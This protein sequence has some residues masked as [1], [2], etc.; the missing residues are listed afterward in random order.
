MTPYDGMVLCQYRDITA[1]SNVK[2]QL[3]R[4]QQGVGRDTESS[5]NR[6]MEIQYKRQPFLLLGAY[7]YFL[8]QRSA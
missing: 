2:L 6:P 3:E 1:R 7:R 5:A 8:R 4:S